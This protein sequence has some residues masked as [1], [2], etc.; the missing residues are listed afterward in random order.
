MS[1]VSRKPQAD[2]V[3]ECVACKS[4]FGF[5]KDTMLE[6]ALPYPHL[7]VTEGLIVCPAC[8]NKI[9][10]Y[11]MSERTRYLLGKVKIAILRW[12]ET[13]TLPVYKDYEKAHKVYK[14][15]YDRDQIRYKEI[16]EG[17]KTD[18]RQK[19]VESSS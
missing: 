17:L 4:R 3:M 14:N 7:T 19:T 18:D 10:C 5:N 12:H 15:S 6:T 11:Y 13:R 16:M 9:H 8:G 1:E 2:V